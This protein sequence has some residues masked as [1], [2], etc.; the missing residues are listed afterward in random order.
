MMHGRKNIKSKKS[1]IW[2]H[3]LPLWRILSFGLWCR[4]VWQK[5]NGAFSRL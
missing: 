3:V 2:G 5:V 4:A 1:D